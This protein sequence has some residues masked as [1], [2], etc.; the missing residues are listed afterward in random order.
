MKRTKKPKAA[1]VGINGFGRRH[2]ELLLGLQEEGWVD[3]AAVS[4]PH[5][6]VEDAALLRSKGIACYS[7]YRKMLS[8]QPGLD[9]AAVSTPIHLHAAMGIEIMEAGIHVLL[10]KPPAAVIQDVDRLI[11]TSRRTGR[12]CAV[13]FLLTSGQAFAEL[14]RII[15]EGRLG[16]RV[17]SVSGI[18]LL[19][20]TDD[21]YRRTY[22]AGKTEAGGQYVLDGT[23]HN[24]LSHLLHNMLVLSGVSVGETQP[25]AAAP[26]DVTG[27]LYHAHEIEGEDT[28][29]LRIRTG[30]EVE[31]YY[32]A[33]LCSPRES[34]PAIRVEGTEGAAIWHYDNSLTVET[35][36]KSV[37]YEF[38]PEDYM[39]NM[40]LN[41]LQAISEADCPLY[42]PVEAA[43]AFL[44]VSNG[45]FESSRFIRPI[46]SSFKE[47]V[48]LG[49]SVL[50]AVRRIDETLE[51][52][53][54]NKLL[55]SEAGVEWA[56][57]AQPFG[58][59]DY[60]RFPVR[61]GKKIREPGGP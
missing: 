41:L 56:H 16:D 23:L 5:V 11:E 12:R 55:L 9:F 29:A 48:E 37:V 50:T 19:Q 49:R 60:D 38:G 46:P 43:R 27:E 3:F 58:L 44:L 39:R 25:S 17:R 1:L 45:A 30:N 31:L 28:A 2:L 53:F 15:R 14:K 52:A 51:Y 47:R 36:G 34:I 24:P 20:R 59:E 13:N 40:Y 26:V 10:E 7:D 35:G 42:C 6:G 18:G 32:Y 57:A 61:F 54:K 33:T 8:E 21:Y 4:E 22:W